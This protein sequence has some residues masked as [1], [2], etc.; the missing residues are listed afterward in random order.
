MMEHVCLGGGVTL[1]RNRVR[2]NIL[3]E[4]LT[5][6]PDFSQLRYIVAAR[7]G[8]SRAQKHPHWGL[9]PPAGVSE[10]NI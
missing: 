6:Q 2:N 9:R 5:P 10:G 7:S 1:R 3:F 8:T 4:G